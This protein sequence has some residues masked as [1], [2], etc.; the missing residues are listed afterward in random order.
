MD[1]THY[2]CINSACS[3]SIDKYYVIS[4]I[5]LVCPQ[6]KEDNPTIHCNE[7]QCISCQVSWSKH[8]NMTCYE[9]K[10]C[11]LKERKFE[12][13]EIK[14]LESGDYQLCPKCS[15]MV[16]RTDGCNHMKCGNINCGTHWCWA[17]GMGDIHIKYRDPYAHYNLLEPEHCVVAADPFS[18]VITTRDIIVQRNKKMLDVVLPERLN[19]N[20]SN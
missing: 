13:W 19:Q 12:D 17:C 20:E 6:P 1:G 8:T 18:N 14:S 4:N 9:Y 5:P 7:V 15:I 11:A 16:I 2:P 3:F 10:L